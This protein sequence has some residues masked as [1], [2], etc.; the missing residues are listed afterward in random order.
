MERSITSLPSLDGT[1]FDIPK[2]GDEKEENGD[3]FIWT[4]TSDGSVSTFE[5]I[6]VPK[7]SVAWEIKW[8]Y[9]G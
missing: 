1:M 6:E 3:K 9:N 2:E 5:W 4:K 8:D 7:P